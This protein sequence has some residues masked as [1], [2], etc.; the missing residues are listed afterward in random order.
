L[1]KQFLF[2]QIINK[3]LDWQVLHVP[4]LFVID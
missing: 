4:V 2:A 3:L 1:D